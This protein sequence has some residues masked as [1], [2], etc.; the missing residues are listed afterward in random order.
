[1]FFRSKYIT[2]YD[3]PMRAGLW[4]ACR[5]DPYLGSQCSSIKCPYI[6]FAPISSCNRTIAARAFV[7]L[8]CIASA[9]SVIFILSITIDD[10]TKKSVL[11]FGRIFAIASLIFGIVGVAVARNLI[12]VTG[13]IHNLRWGSSSI[14][15]LIAIIINFVGAL[16]SFLIKKQSWNGPVK[17]PG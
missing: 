6:E 7:T 9:L 17:L 10:T 16:T 8:A 15:G 4:E 11:I 5:L 2:E 3:I 1:M 14:M 12:I 13:S